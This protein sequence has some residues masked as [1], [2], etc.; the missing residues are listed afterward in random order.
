M[1]E[2]LAESYRQLLEECRRRGDVLSEPL[3]R[4]QRRH[5]RLRVNPARLTQALSPW[6]LAVDISATGMAF[7]V[8]EPPAT[9]SPIKIALGNLLEA[10][11]DVLACQEVPLHILRDPP[12]Y[13]VRCQFTDEEQGLRML[14]AIKEME[15]ARA[16]PD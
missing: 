16:N 8:E 1:D 14:V 6:R 2:R 9:G 3:G 10:E 12:R 11:A 15:D 7:Y 13:R 5:P 4:E